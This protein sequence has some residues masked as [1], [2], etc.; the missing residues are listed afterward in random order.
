MPLVFPNWQVKIKKFLFS[1]WPPATLTQ[2]IRGFTPSMY[3]VAKFRGSFP[4]R[5]K[6]FFFRTL[7]NKKII[8]YHLTFY[9]VS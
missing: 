5:G 8:F 4:N 7:A 1:L 9:D 2:V 6:D 3:A